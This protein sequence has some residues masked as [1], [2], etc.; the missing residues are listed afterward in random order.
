MA[1]NSKGSLVVFAVLYGICASGMLSL[2]PAAATSLTEDL[3]KAGVRLG[4]IMSCVSFACLTGPP[5][6][7]WLLQAREGSYIGAQAFFGSVVAAA[8]G[9]LIGARFLKTKGA[10]IMRA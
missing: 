4:M 9:F 6:G 2:F 5:I 8:V 7:G 10:L 3:S 1:I